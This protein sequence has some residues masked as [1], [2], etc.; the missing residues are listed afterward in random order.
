MID[1]KWVLWNRDLVKVSE[2]E[3][4]IEFLEAFSEIKKRASL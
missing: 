3:L 4:K 2:E 1:G